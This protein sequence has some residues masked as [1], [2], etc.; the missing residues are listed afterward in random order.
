MTNQ[1]IKIINLGGYKIGDNGVKY[2]S[3]ALKRNQTLTD[4]NL[5]FNFIGDDGG[6]NDQM[7]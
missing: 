1:T 6:K 2:V 7:F 5:G 4:I 3:V